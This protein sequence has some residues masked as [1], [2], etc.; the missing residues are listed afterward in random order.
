MVWRTAMPRLGNESHCRQPHSLD[1][2]HVPSSPPGADPCVWTV[3]PCG[4]GPYQPGEEED[5]ASY[6]QVTKS[7]VYRLL[8]DLLPTQAAFP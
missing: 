1:R 6:D 4:A 8:K 3:P 5:Y 2:S 7:E